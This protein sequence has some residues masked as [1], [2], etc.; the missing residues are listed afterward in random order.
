MIFTDTGLSKHAENKFME[1]LSVRHVSK[2][3][4]VEQGFKEVSI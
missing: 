2:V 3:M 4:L 1:V